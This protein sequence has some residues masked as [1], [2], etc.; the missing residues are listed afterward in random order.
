M[1]LAQLASAVEEGRDELT[2]PGRLMGTIDY[3]APEQ[4]I[5]AKS[6]DCRAD[7]YSLGCSMFYLLTARNVIPEGSFPHKLLWHQTRAAPS[8]REACPEAPDELDEIFQRMV[9]K[10]PQDRQQSMVEVEEDLDRCLREMMEGGTGLG[11]RGTEL[12]MYIG[13]SVET[14]PPVPEPVTKKE[15]AD[16]PAVGAAGKS[17]S[18]PPWTSGPVGEIM[19][20]ILYGQNLATAAAL[21]GRRVRAV[22]ERGESISGVVDRLSL[23]IDSQNANQRVLKLHIGDRRIELENVR[24]VLS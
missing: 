1:G 12:A 11:L 6:V 23:E 3:M 19:R 9:A 21:I 16:R 24:E 14:A 15:V 22:S 2:E 7:I 13:M 4:A 18:R 20:V 8:L 5:D 10:K 17:R